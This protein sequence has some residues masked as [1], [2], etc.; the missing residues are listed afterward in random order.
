MSVQEQVNTVP[1]LDGVCVARKG[2]V[3]MISLLC[4][5]PVDMIQE[6][7]RS[8]RIGILSVTCMFSFTYLLRDINMA[9]K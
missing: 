1:V 9:G 2:Q 5:G 7:C 6:V 4:A 8:N 3:T